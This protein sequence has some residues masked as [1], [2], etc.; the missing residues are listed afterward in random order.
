MHVPDFLP[1]SHKGS[2]QS[3][4]RL[5]GEPRTVVAGEY[6]QCVVG[7]PGLVQS[8]QHSSRNPIHLRDGVGKGRLLLRR[9][10]RRRRPLARRLFGRVGTGAELVD[11]RKGQVQ[12]K[13]LGGSR[14]AVDK[15]GRRVGVRFCQKVGPHGLLDDAVVLVQ[16]QPLHAIGIV[17]NG[18]PCTETTASSNNPCGPTFW[19]KRTPTR[20]LVSSTATR[21]PPS[22]FSCTWPFRTSTNSVPV[23]TR[24]NSRTCQ[25]ASASQ[26][27][28]A[29]FAD[30]VTVMDWIAGRVLLQALDQAGLTNDTLVVFTSDNGPWLAEQSCAGLS[31]PFVGQW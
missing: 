2:T 17:R 3:S 27:Q 15:A 4:A 25:W 7:D 22:P 29:T 11:V 21:L 1:L 18:C 14:V 19:Q 16:R 24:R 10:R 12:E 9:R 5:F 28:H 13:G 26:Q 23:P 6:H 20:H 8:Q 30:A 31:G